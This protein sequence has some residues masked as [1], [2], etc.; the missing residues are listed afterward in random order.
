M[1]NILKSL[2]VLA[3]TL[4]ISSV[5]AWG[6]TGHRV[7]AEVAERHLTKKAK[8]NIQ[9]IIGKQ[10]LAY[11]ANWGDFIKS[12]PHDEFKK[13]GNSHFINTNPHLPWADF[14]LAMENS[15]EENLY[16]TVLRLEKSFAE[17]DL[18]LEKKKQNLYMLIHLIGDAHQPMHVSRAEDQGGNKIEVSWFGKKSNIHRVWDSDLIDGEKYSYTEYATVLDILSKNEVKQVQG[19][20]LASW[21]YESNQLSDKIYADVELNANLSYNYI[22]NNIYKAE[23]CMLRGGLRLAKILN[24]VFG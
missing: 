18:T 24:D 7:V 3:M 1:K 9:K 15:N 20:T 5:F 2:I 19:G 12:D 21:L 11:W 8:K 14:Q 22:Y 23:N 6:S 10:K 17:K 16:K 4:Q 13:L